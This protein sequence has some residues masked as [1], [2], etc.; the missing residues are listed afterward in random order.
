[1]K[2]LFLDIDGVLNS[3]A[4]LLALAKADPGVKVV[5]GG[6]DFTD[7]LDPAR[8]MK[9]NAIVDA[10]SCNVVLSSSWRCMRSI[11]EVQRM[12]R[13]RGYTGRLSSTTPRLMGHE[14]HV[15]IRRWLE[16]KPVDRFAILDDD[17]DAGVGFGHWFVRTADGIEDEHV[18]RVIEVLGR[19][20]AGLPARGT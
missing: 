4:Y 10:T 14:R 16:G 5:D 15:E 2:V 20:A 18:E 7:H 11:G 1:M 13:H 3:S 9:L 8:V 17:Q 19:S 6:W 12:L